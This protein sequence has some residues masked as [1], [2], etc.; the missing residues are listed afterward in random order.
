MGA[1]GSIKIYDGEKVLELLKMIDWGDTFEDFKKLG[2][3][4][5]YERHLFGKLVFTVYYGEHT[6][7]DTF[8]ALEYAT[9]PLFDDDAN[10][11][12]QSNF[13]K[14]KRRIS[15]YTEEDDID[16]E[17]DDLFEDALLDVWEVWI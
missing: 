9:Y 17:S 14:L 6:D 11:I 16:V 13:E 15:G 5:I 7:Y 2:N 1:K 4:N 10:K 8:V 12:R 3:G